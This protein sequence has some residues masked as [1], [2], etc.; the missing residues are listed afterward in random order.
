MSLTRA[1][2]LI[3]NRPPALI[4]T[5]T[6]SLPPCSVQDWFVDSAHDDWTSGLEEGEGDAAASAI[7]NTTAPT[8]AAIT[9]RALQQARHDRVNNSLTHS[10]TH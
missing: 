9:L 8:D 3:V 7:N 6:T 2:A 4:Y 10:L 5:H 1:R